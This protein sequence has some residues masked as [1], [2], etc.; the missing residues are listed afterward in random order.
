[1]SGIYG[2]KCLNSKSQK[3]KSGVLILAGRSKNSNFNYPHSCRNNQSA[4]ASLKN[5]EQNFEIY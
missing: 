5:S 4:N 3:M 2:E 1:L